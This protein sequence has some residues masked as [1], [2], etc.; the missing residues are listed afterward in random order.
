M[1]VISKRRAWR[2]RRGRGHTADGQKRELFFHHSAGTFF[3]AAEGID[4]WAEQAEVMRRMQNFH[5]D[6]RGWADISYNYVVFQPYGKLRQARI[7]EGRPVTTVPAA[8]LGHNT[9]TIAVVI[10]DGARGTKLKLST[11]LQ[12]IRLARKLK[13]EHGITAMG[14][15]RDAPGQ[16]TSC[17]GDYIYPALNEIARRARLRRIK[18]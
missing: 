18:R 2:A 12:M 6:T 13:R 11:K 14:G 16:S 3:G 1:I 15:H 8:Q 10:V 17:P 5:I 7:F 4:T 9:G